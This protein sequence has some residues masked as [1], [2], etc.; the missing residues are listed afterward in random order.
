MYATNHPY[1]VTNL[2]SMGTP[3]SGSAFSELP[4]LINA[5]GL[6]YAV[7][8]HSGQDITSKQ[9]QVELKNNWNTMLSNNPNVNINAV[10]IGSCTSSDYLEE[11]FAGGYVNDELY[12]LLEIDS[13]A[14]SFFEKVKFFIV[15]LAA[16]GIT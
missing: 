7:H 6:C 3:Y 13:G 4:R 15:N 11:L 10:A 9:K 2:I 14:A 8:C 1:N 16:N 5:V 12:N